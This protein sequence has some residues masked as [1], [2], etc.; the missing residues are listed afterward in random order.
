MYGADVRRR[1]A[2]WA[3]LAVLL[4]AACGGDPTGEGNDDSPPATATSPAAASTPSATLPVAEPANVEAVPIEP[5]V[6]ARLKITGE[7]DWMAAGSGSLWVKTAAGYVQRI[8]PATNQVLTEIEVPPHQVPGCEGL[9]AS[10]D[11]VW[12]CSE[13]DIVRIDPATNDVAATVAVGKIHDQGHIPVAFGRAWV[14]TGD[15]S[16][17]VG[18]AEDAVA[19]KIELGTRCT[20]LTASATAV[21]AACPVDGIAIAVDPE[22]DAVTSRVDRLTDARTISAHGGAVWVGFRGALARVDEATGQITGVADASSADGDVAAID[23]A[24]WVRTGGP[25]LRRVDPDT[26]EVV[27]DLTAPESGGGPVLVAFGS[28]WAASYDDKVLYRVRPD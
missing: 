3:V 7:P 1:G 28:V 9:G 21:W 20:E 18:V 5:R 23:D 26:L 12:T 22:Q 25:F 4:V 19:S 10:D 6:E 14:L 13:Q 2:L 16:T 11:A 8:D 17:L 15:G 27:E 24:V